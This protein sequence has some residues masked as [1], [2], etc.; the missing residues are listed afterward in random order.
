MW[1]IRVASLSKR[2]LVRSRAVKNKQDNKQT[3]RKPI[4]ALP[5]R[6]YPSIIRFRVASLSK[7]GLVR[8]RAVKNKQQQKREAIWGFVHQSPHE[9]LVRGISLKFL[10]IRIFGDYF[11]RSWNNV[12]FDSNVK[13]NADRYKSLKRARGLANG[14]IIGMNYK[15][16]SNDILRRGQSRFCIAV[17]HIS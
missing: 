17:G 5:V 11:R 15:L 16:K 8:S 7:Q 9:V 10:K 6:V 14:Q 12:S 1:N 4:D 13:S 2:G 3:L